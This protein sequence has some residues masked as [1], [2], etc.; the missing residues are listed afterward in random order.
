MP[1]TFR[2]I[3][4]MARVST[5]FLYR[6]PEMRAR[7]QQLRD[8]PSAALKVPA[9]IPANNMVQVLKHRIEDDRRRHAEEVLRLQGELAAA[10]AQVLDVSRRL[11]EQGM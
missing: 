5:D 2:G 3:S 10:R 6:H 1:V 8:G 9:A 4:A 7:I 11:R